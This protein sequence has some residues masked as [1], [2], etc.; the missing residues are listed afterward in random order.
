MNNKQDRQQDKILESSHFF[1]IGIVVNNIEET[2]KY[3]EEV[4]GMGPF[5]KRT[6]HYD[7]ATFYGETCGYS[8]KRA[9]FNL[10]PVQVELIELIDGKTIHEQFLKEKGPGLHHI[11]FRVKDLQ[12]AKE[13]A[14]KKGLEV[15]QD[16]QH[17]GGLGFAYLDSDK[18]GGVIFELIQLPERKPSPDSASPPTKQN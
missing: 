11:G 5:E 13:N 2:T 4:F 10:G 3:Y 8:G 1:Q 15:I 14:R 12:Q 17:P 6:V 9:F 7:N 18:I 16:Y